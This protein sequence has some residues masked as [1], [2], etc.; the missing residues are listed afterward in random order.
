MWQHSSQLFTG[1]PVREAIV[2]GGVGHGT[3]VN[4]LNYNDI[5]FRLIYS[6]VLHNLNN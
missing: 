5:S 1:W 2:L 3:L 6:G 4:I